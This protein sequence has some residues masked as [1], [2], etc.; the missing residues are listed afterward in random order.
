MQYKLDRDSALAIMGCVDLYSYASV[1]ET[2]SS[3]HTQNLR[4]AL[5]VGRSGPSEPVRI[6]GVSK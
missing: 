2:S 6:G 4:T 1:M 5:A 3:R